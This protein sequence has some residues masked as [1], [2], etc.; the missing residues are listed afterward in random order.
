LKRRQK[1]CLIPFI[2]KKFNK[3]N[4]LQ[5]DP[6]RH[7]KAYSP[8]IILPNFLAPAKTQRRASNFILSRTTK[9]GELLFRNTL[10]FLS[11]QSSQTVSNMREDKALRCGEAPVARSFHHSSM[12]R[13]PHCLGKIP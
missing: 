12:L 7:T 1:L 5:H 13:A 8:G 10:A 9:E 4:G 2:K 6:T 3:D 11:F